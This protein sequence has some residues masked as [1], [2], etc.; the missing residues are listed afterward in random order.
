ML[1]S[2]K[3]PLFKPLWNFWFVLY[4]LGSQG[5]IILMFGMLSSQAGFKIWAV[6]VYVCDVVGPISGI[7]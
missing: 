5:V 6:E 3:V 4:M 7:L 2:N 1:L